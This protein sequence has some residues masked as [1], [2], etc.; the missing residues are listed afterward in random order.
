MY[1]WLYSS[2]QCL[3]WRYLHYC[4]VHSS[5][6]DFVRWQFMPDTYF[7]DIILHWGLT[8]FERMYSYWGIAT[9]LILTLRLDLLFMIAIFDGS[10]SYWHPRF[11][12]LNILD[13]TWIPTFLCWTSRHPTFNTIIIPAS[14][15]AKPDQY[16]VCLFHHPT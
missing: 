12:L 10:Y 3:I 13:S 15:L 5:V 11:S 9:L 2:H 4:I 7:P 1:D 8:H 16:W 6:I 14:I